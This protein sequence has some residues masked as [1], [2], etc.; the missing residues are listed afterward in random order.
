MEPVHFNR[1]ALRHFAGKD[2]HFERETFQFAHCRVVAGEDSEGREKLFQAMDNQIARA[3]HPLAESLNH[4]VA[5]VAVDNEARKEIG[6]GENETAGVGILHDAFPVANGGSQAAAK[7]FRIDGFGFG[8]EKTE[9]DLGGGTV[10]SDADWAPTWIRYFDGIA[11]LG[12]TAV[13]YVA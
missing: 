1:D 6:F 5:A 7:E 3:V 8:G 4:K 10:V 2:S 11:G 13:G 9:G 12:G